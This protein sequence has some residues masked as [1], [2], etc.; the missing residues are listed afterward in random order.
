LR[1]E[2]E[3]VTKEEW[4]EDEVAQK[5]VDPTQVRVTNVVKMDKFD[6][7]VLQKMKTMTR[8]L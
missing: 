8:Q 2:T 1:K 6:E 4:G 5:D 7:I 3:A